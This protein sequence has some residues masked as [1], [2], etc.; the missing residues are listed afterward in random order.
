MKHLA[1]YIRLLPLTDFLSFDGTK[2]ISKSGSD[3]D[4]LVSRNDLV[5]DPKPGNGG[6]GTFYTEEIRVVTDKLTES[7]RSVY[8]NRRPVV[9]LLYDDKGTPI[10]WGEADQKVRV[11]LTPN[12]DSD[13]LDLARKT[14]T[15][16]F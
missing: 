8:C 16:L 4:I 13:I 11:T 5:F 2:L 1:N 15:S 12:I 10:L 3:P 7:Q 9:V 14:T 6:G